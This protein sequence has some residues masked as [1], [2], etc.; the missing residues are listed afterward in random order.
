M[1]SAVPE[2][3]GAM[4]AILGLKAEMIEQICER[5]PGAEVVFPANY[6]TPE[7]T[8]IAGHKA[9]VERVMQEAQKEG[10]KRTI[11]LPVSVPSHCELMKP[12]AHLL[13]EALYSIPFQLPIIPVIHNVDAAP[14]M[15]IVDIRLALVDQLYKPVRWV[16]TVQAIAKLGVTEMWECGP[17]NV[18]SGL[19]KRINAAIVC[20]PLSNGEAYVLT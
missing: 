9:A 5:L 3:V 7:Q 18:L 12:A 19:N 2:G 8:V 11:P 20:Q 13:E 1:Q 16:Q 14:R 10:A 15:K 17:G 4:A 6:N